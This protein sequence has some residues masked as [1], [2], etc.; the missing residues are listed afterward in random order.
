MKNSL[1]YTIFVRDFVE[2]ILLSLNLDY[3]NYISINKKNGLLKK[4]L[5]TYRLD[6][7]ITR[8]AYNVFIMGKQK[9]V[10]YEKNN[11]IIISINDDYDEKIINKFIIKCPKDVI[12]FFKRRKLKR[13]L[14]KM[15]YPTCINN[16]DKNFQR[17]YLFIIDVIDFTFEKL[18]KD[19]LSTKASNDK[20]TSEYILFREIRKRKKQKLLINH[21]FNEINKQLHKSLNINDKD[22]VIT[23]NSHSLKELD[24]LEKDLLN[25]NKTLKEI[26]NDLFYKNR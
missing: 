4:K 21:I 15:K 6:T 25:S 19:Y 26:D 10:L 20:Y 13:A 3:N 17:D 24:S 5:D 8:I 1:E 2:N 14:N 16:N 7:I 22:D 23:F 18:T 12:T 9:I 11:K